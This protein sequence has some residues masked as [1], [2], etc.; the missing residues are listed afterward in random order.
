MQQIKKKNKFSWI[1]SLVVMLLLSGAVILLSDRVAAVVYEPYTHSQT[2]NF[3]IDQAKA[4]D[5]PA[6]AEEYHV[7][8]VDFGYDASGNLVAYT[9]ETWEYGFNA[10]T[11]IVIRSTISADGTLLAGIEVVSE[12]ETKYYGAQISE[13]YFPDQFTG[14]TLPLLLYSQ[15]GRG[16]RVDGVSGATVTSGAVVRAINNAQRFV[17]EQL[18]G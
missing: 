9:V 5:L 16:T 2:V 15:S 7:N 4:M 3:T 17:T 1:T 12:K 8:A 18:N 11:P 10:E 6:S 14:R 13:S